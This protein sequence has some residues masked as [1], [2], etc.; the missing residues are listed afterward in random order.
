MATRLLQR[1]GS[2]KEWGDANPILGAGEL[3]VNPETGE[4]VVGDGV[5][6]WSTLPRPYLRKAGGD[7]IV[8]SGVGVVPLAL[9]PSVGQTANLLEVQNAAATALLARIAANGTV[10]SEKQGLFG[11]GAAGAFG[12]G[13]SGLAVIGQVNNAPSLIVRAIAGH[14][15]GV[16]DFQSSSGLTLASIDARGLGLFAPDGAGRSTNA[17]LEVHPLAANLEGVVIK[18]LG[19]QAASLLQLRNGAGSTL[20]QIT[21]LGR[22]VQGGAP[23]GAEMDIHIPSNNTGLILRGAPSQNSNLAEFQNSAGSV[24]LSVRN[25]GVLNLSGGSVGYGSATGGNFAIP[26]LC[27]G[28]VRIQANGTEYRIPVFNP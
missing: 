2:A 26:G 11:P 7:V 20:A 8:A 15:G 24:L 25:D 17:G 1:R 28:F 5:K 22:W 16:A 9:R 27:A 10:I 21:A 19:S 13:G 23:L 12:A 4:H 3:G 14:V 18:G 6:I